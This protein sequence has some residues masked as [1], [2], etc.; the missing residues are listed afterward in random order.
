MDDT[1]IESMTRFGQFE[2]QPFAMQTLTMQSLASSPFAM[3]VDPTSIQEA[4]ERIGRMALPRL[5]VRAFTDKE[6]PG[7]KPRRKAA[8]VAAVATG[9]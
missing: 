5:V 4:A 7:R 2:P 9:T 8:A 3:L 6:P 1:S